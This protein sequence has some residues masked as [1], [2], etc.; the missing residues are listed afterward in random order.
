MAS[1]AMAPSRSFIRT[2]IRHY[3][4]PVDSSIPASKTKYIPNSGTYPKGFKVSGT[5]VGVKPANKTQPDLAFIVSDRPAVGAAV[6]TTNKFQAAPVQVSRAVLEKREGK[7][8]R[9]IIVNSGCANAVT[10]AGGL[11]DAKAM[12]ETATAEIQKHSSQQTNATTS[13]AGQVPNSLVMS[14]GVIGQ[15]LP[16]SKILSKIPT[17]YANLDNSHTAWLT[18]A[19]AIC[20]T[21]TFPKL[22]ST[23]FT[24]PSPRHKGIEYRL[25]GMTKGAGMIHPNMATLLGIMCTDA[26]IDAKALK[27]LLTTAVNQSF[28]CISV[29]GDTSTNDTV[30]ILANGAAAA[31]AK[32]EA[33]T[34]ISSDSSEDYLAMSHILTTFSQKLAQLVVRDGEGATKFVEVAVRHAPTHADARA[35]ASTIARSPLVKTALYGKDAN[36][37]RILCAIGYTPDLTPGAVIPSKTN[38]SFVPAENSKAKSEGVLK[39]LVNGEPEQV[40]EARAAR[41]LEDEDLVIEVD[42][43]TGEEEAKYWFCD[44]SHEYVTING[45]YRT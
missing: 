27:S 8:V 28:N 14:T 17:A 34:P 6:F 18:A 19:K 7:D 3:S 33:I 5:H 44:F 11:E 2:C 12:A 32:A 15:R 41:L 36:W 29:D 35:I 13:S 16:I 30:A 23:T 39:L 24:L 22:L 40:D 38:V 37:G 21:D 10:G 45:D 43:G 42:L 20:T 1:S 31:E 25:A 26:P 4:A 9:A